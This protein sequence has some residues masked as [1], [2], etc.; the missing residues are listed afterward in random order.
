MEHISTVIAGNS[1][2]LDTTLDLSTRL[3]EMA[4]PRSPD[5]CWAEEEVEETPF[6]QY[7][8]AL[9]ACNKELTKSGRDQIVSLARTM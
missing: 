6:W 9:F 3:T 7:Q 1:E 5:L 8:V 4:L 2:L